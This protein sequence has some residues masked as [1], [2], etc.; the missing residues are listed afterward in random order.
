MD[1]DL[2]LCLVQ[3][4][5]LGWLWS[6]LFLSWAQDGAKAWACALP[7]PGVRLGF[8]GLDLDGWW[9]WSCA[10]PGPGPV[11][12]GGHCLHWRGG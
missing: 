9:Y 10:W 6:L 2:G 1:L 8:L 3:G 4:L 7:F 5:V 12:P 11:D